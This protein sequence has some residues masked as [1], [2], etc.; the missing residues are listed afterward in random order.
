[1]SGL[2]YGALRL[3]AE[4][5]PDYAWSLVG[6]VVGAAGSLI[7]LFATFLVFGR[8]RRRTYLNELLL[9]S[10][11]A[12]LALSNLLFVT[13]PTVA[14]WAPDDLTVWAAPL[15]RALGG[16]LFILA[17]FVPRREARRAGLTIALTAVAVIT[18]IGLAAIF[19]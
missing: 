6:I 16:L 8:L 19:V 4:V 11:L 7:A 2:A 18:A 17:A 9:A 3:L 13:V 15:A 14:N 5:P 1:A 12:V 10:A